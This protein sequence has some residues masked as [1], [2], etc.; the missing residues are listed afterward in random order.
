[1]IEELSA[2]LKEG[3]VV[4]PDVNCNHS[5]ITPDLHKV[6]KVLNVKTCSI[7]IKIENE[8]QVRI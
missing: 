6:L 7:E 1:M 3:A 4:P 2:R 8:Q 5:R